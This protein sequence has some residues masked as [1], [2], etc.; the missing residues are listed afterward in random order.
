MRLRE[1]GH[2][3]DALP[4]RR[5]LLPR[6][7]YAVAGRT[8]CHRGSHRTRSRRRAATRRVG[9]EAVD[10]AG[11]G[12]TARARDRMP[13]QRGRPDEELPALARHHHALAGPVRPGRALG[14][15]LQRRRHDLAVLRQP[16]R[17]ARRMGARSRPRGRPH[18]ARA[19]RV[20]DRGYSHHDPGAPR[21]PPDRRIPRRLTFDQVGR[22]RS[23]PSRVQHERARGCDR[24]PTRGR[25]GHAARRTHGARRSRRSPVFG[26][27]VAPRRAG[28]RRGRAACAAGP[29]HRPPEVRVRPATAR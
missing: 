23:R 22:G 8:L 5:V 1:R 4:G 28:R 9:R 2:R 26:E 24:D 12:G 11:R 14:R 18:G 25:R 15:R 17:Q 19:H 6:D 3:R 20:R 10:R 7:E 29:V 13:H 16:R 21:A 27:G